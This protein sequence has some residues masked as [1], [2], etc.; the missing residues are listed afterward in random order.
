M[1]ETYNKKLKKYI[2]NKKMNNLNISIIDG[3]KKTDNLYT[4]ISTITIK[5]RKN[6]WNTNTK[7]VDTK[8]KANNSNIFINIA[9]INKKINNLSR[10]KHRYSRHKK[11]S[12]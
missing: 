6:N 10:H 12:Q 4:N 2:A 1:I 11:N 3:N 8:K 5:K 9:D 7:R